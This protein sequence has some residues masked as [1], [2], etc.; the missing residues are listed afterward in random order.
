MDNQVILL[1][2]ITI[3]FAVS[4]I[5]NITTLQKVSKIKNQSKNF[6]SG[7]N[8]KDLEE[9]INK[10]KKRLDNVD[11]EIQELFEASNKIHNLALKGVHQVGLLRFNPFKDIGGD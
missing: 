8:G 10:H 6:F 3:M 5:F 11:K 4:L 2:S 9:V 1:I 7:K